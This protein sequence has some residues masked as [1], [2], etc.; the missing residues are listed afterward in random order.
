MANIDRSVAEVDE[1]VKKANE[2]ASAE[3]PSLLESEGN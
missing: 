3:L 1:A 2:G